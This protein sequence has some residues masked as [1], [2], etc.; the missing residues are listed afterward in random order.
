[1]PIPATSVD[2]LARFLNSILT[3]GHRQPIPLVATHIDVTIRGG[4]AIV[5][6]ERT[7]RNIEKKSIEAT[8]T[9]PVPVDATLCKLSARIDERA[10]SAIA[11][12]RATARE[13]YEHALDSG[14]GA[15]LHEELLKGIHMLSV[16]HLRPGGEVVVI[17]TWT[18]FLSFVNGS[19]RLRIPTTVGEIYGRSPLAPSDDLRT[20]NRATS[21]TIAIACE[22]GTASLLRG[23]APTGGRFVIGLDAPI[24]ITIAGWSSKKLSGVAADGRTTRLE[25]K[26][27]HKAI[28]DLDLDVLFDHSGSMQED[29]SG[30]DEIGGS[31]F[32]VAKSALAAIL[33]AE[34][35]PQDRIRLWEFNDEVRFVGECIGPCEALAGQLQPP[36]GGT[37]IGR[38]FDTVI[39]SKKAKNV[40]IVTDGKSWALDAQKIAR[41]GL[42][43]HAVLIG[44]DALEAD[45]AH[46]AG[47]SGGQVFVATG[48]EAGAA[49]AAAF[50]AARSPH[51][52]RQPI[53]GQPTRVEA[54]RRGAHVVATWGAKGK[55]EPSPAARQIGATAAMLAIPLLPEKAAAQLAEAEGIVTHLTSLVLVD[56]AGERQKGIP[57]S[58]KVPLSPSRIGGRVRQG[59]VLSSLAIAPHM[60]FAK[61]EMGDFASLQRRRSDGLSL[62]GPDD[63]PVATSPFDLASAVDRIDWDADPDA[64]CR[65][66][67]SGLAADVVLAIRLA[68]TEPEIIA[69]ADELGIDAVVVVIALL[70]KRA[71]G[72][73][74]SAARVARAILARSRA[75][76][77]TAA[78]AHVGL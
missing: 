31:K 59:V 51:E 63:E 14:K 61:R 62:I 67:L 21:A 40:V 35:K 26:P 77:L 27:G 49:L 37:E 47:M 12:P 54:F 29:A 28:S 1:M 6:T 48:C 22:N 44:E 41:S 7:F 5:A 33:R 20:G 50:M 43:V 19:P 10:L 16:G 18:A 76:A 4:L 36:S 74:R 39:A 38:A 30:D 13:T 11:Q 53:S 8:L 42:R 32:E 3:Q 52:R 58:R 72:G 75:D 71:S 55:V 2:P 9:F 17:D 60:P 34:L 15:I 70:A 65:A 46:L 23:G 24:D 69:F 64:L 78:M 66:D 57:A 56:E 25:V 73:N 45:I 68:A